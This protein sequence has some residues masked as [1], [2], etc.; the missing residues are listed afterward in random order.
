MLSSQLQG[1][2]FKIGNLSNTRTLDTIIDSMCKDGV[3]SVVTPKLSEFLSTSLERHMRGVY[4]QY[5][6]PVC[7]ARFNEFVNLVYEQA[8]SDEAKQYIINLV[9]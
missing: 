6:H 2:S 4:Y 3:I 5:H 8:P 7:S 1:T 9:K